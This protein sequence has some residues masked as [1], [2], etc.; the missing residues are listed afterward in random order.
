MNRNPALSAAW[1]R[2][3]ATLAESPTPSLELLDELDSSAT[4]TWQPV[5][6]FDVPVAP[7]SADRPLPS[8]ST[9][10]LVCALESASGDVTRDVG[11]KACAA[12]ETSAAARVASPGP[13][14]VTRSAGGAAANST[15][16]RSAAAQLSGE[17]RLGGGGDASRKAA[18]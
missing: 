13:E 3:D 16:S 2:L 4:G 15:D 14:L 9:H 6:F 18:R 8:T 11:R 1:A 12:A 7:Y 10:S 5:R 17:R